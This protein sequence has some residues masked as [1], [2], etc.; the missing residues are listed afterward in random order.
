MHQITQR[1]ARVLQG[2]VTGHLRIKQTGKGSPSAERLLRQYNRHLDQV[3]GLVEG[4]CHDYVLYVRQFLQWRF[5]RRPL[6]FRVLKPR[7]MA[8]F[9]QQR[10]AVLQSSTLHGVAAALRSFFRFLHFTGR[11]PEWL[12]A[13]VV[14]PAPRPPS[15]IPEALSEIEL[16]CFLKTFDRTQPIGRRDFAM[17]LCLCRLGLRAL[18]VASLRLADVDCHAQTLHLRHTKTGQGRLLPLPP[19]VAEAIRAYEQGG[20]PATDAQVLFVR[21]R[22][23]WDAGRRSDLVLMA[24][25]SAFI[26]AGLMHKGAHILRH[27]FAT[28]LHRRGVNLKIIADLLGHRSLN[29][30]SRYARINLVELRQ[31]ALPWP[32]L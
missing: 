22:A 25:R 19:D 3:A 18:E 21:H 16:R 29:T 7:D 26:R 30:T 6:R 28:R 2:K 12:A 5:G 32:E 15:R 11:A 1:N 4:T 31:A 10:G 24:M 17:A 9:M 13:A 14:C 23:P 20:R 27:T 8:G